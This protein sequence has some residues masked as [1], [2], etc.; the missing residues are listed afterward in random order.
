MAK[1]N[2]FDVDKIGG[3]MEPKECAICGQ[4]SAYRTFFNPT[5]MN[6]DAEW[7]GDYCE[8]HKPTEKQL[9]DIC[10]GKTPIRYKID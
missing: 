10:K 4:V 5:Y 8:I 3:Y 9:I 7:C 6:G 2:T 1:A